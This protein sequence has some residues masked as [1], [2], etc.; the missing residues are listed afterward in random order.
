M[1]MQDVLTRNLQKLQDDAEKNESFI[2]VVGPMFALAEDESDDG[3][4]LI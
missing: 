1:I 2:G 4:D 3:I